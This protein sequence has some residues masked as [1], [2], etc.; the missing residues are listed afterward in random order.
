M[1]LILNSDLN[2]DSPT[3]LMYGAGLTNS[4]CPNNYYVF[5]Q[6][7]E[8]GQLA[9]LKAAVQS[10]QQETGVPREHYLDVCV[11]VP[12]PKT[13]PKDQHPMTLLA[14]AGY[15]ARK[16]MLEFLIREGASKK[17]RSADKQSHNLYRYM[18]ASVPGFPHSVCV[19]IIR[20]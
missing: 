1:P 11:Q 2:D 7:I 13:S 15:H 3:V 19:L 12:G 18:T 8:N 6:A 4:F 16:D 5:L 20:I 14:F 9:E 17:L 10:M